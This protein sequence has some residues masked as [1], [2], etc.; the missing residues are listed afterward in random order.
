MLSA[1]SILKVNDIE[2]ESRESMLFACLND[3]DDDNFKKVG[4]D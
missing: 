1:V 2:R 3:D 4:E